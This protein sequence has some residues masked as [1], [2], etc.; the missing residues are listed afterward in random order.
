[1][2]VAPTLHD[3]SRYEEKVAYQDKLISELNEVVVGL[4]IAKVTGP[5]GP[6][7]AP[8]APPRRRAVA[9][10][11]CRTRSRRIIDCG[12]VLVWF[13]VVACLEGRPG[14][15]FVTL[16]RNWRSASPSLFTGLCSPLCLRWGRSTI[17]LTLRRNG[18]SASPSF[19]HSGLLGA[20]VI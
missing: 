12:T 15:P 2:S 11:K 4:S 13:F 3:C 6:H 14:D 17:V 9:D 8:G 10:A 5:D 18:R 1:M 19:V 20:I 7:R 16:T